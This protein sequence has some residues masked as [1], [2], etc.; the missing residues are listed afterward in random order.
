MIFFTLFVAVSISVTEF[1][2]IETTASVF[3]IG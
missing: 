2:A 3:G 1:E